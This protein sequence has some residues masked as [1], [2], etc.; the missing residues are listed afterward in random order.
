MPPRKRRSYTAEYKVEAAHRVIDSGRTISEVAHE[1]GIDPGM[2]SVWVKDERRR[3]AAAEVLGDKPLEAAER[4]EL[5]RLRG[6][7]AELSGLND[8]ACRC[9]IRILRDR[10]HRVGCCVRVAGAVIVP[11]RRTSNGRTRVGVIDPMSTPA[12]HAPTSPGRD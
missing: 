4:A 9:I 12:R 11:D 6:Q 8:D 1:L 3:V 2:L 5:A 7:V 10:T